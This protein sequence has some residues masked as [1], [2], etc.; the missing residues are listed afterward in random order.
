MKLVESVLNNEQNEIAVIIFCEVHSN[1]VPVWKG[2]ICAVTWAVSL[3][4]QPFWRQLI[5]IKYCGTAEVSGTAVGM[6]ED[7]ASRVSFFD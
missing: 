2:Y 5:I 7:K 4:V 1:C 6:K 3:K